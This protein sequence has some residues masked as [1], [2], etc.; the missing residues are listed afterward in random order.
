MA[1]DIG[2]AQKTG[3]F[4]PQF[5]KVCISNLVTWHDKTEITPRL[6]DR[7]NIEQI[8]M[9]HAYPTQSKRQAN[10]ELARPAN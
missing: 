7:A 2:S 6:H 10:I 8:I 1:T 4:T 5:A 3:Q 9:K